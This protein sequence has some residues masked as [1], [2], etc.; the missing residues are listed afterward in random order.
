MNFNDREEF[1]QH[2]FRHATIEHIATGAR[3]D[4]ILSISKLI[5]IKQVGH[6]STPVQLRCG[7]VENLNECLAF[8]TLKIPC[9]MA[10]LVVISCKDNA[11][12]LKV[13]DE[14]SGKELLIRCRDFAFLDSQN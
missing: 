1:A 12:V 11:A 2:D 9:E 5:W 4:L 6:R 13:T 8:F 7:G 3:R 14:R 10:N